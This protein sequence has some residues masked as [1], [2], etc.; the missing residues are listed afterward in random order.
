MFAEIIAFV[1]LNTMHARDL[2]TTTAKNADL[3]KDKVVKESC[4]VKR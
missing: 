4:G 1:F 2:W 3:H